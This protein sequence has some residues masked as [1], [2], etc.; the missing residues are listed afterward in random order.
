MTWTQTRQKFQIIQ[1]NL[2]LYKYFAEYLNEHYT[3]IWTTS[4]VYNMYACEY[5]HMQQETI[6]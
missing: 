2:I 3:I 5:V 1:L 4:H 6:H